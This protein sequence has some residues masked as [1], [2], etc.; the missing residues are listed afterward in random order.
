MQMGSK[1]DLCRNAAEVLMSSSQTLRLPKE[2]D[3]SAINRGDIRLYNALIQ[4]MSNQ[5]LGFHAGMEQT[6]GKF[7]G[8]CPVCLWWSSISRYISIVPSLLC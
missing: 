6:S 2:F 3:T 4:F 1:S 8:T 5:S 7:E